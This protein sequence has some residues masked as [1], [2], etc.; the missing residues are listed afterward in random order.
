M[1]YGP[2]ATGAPAA[3]GAGAVD[4]LQAHFQ[5]AAT[6]ACLADAA[7][8]AGVMRNLAMES[9]CSQ[10]ATSDL[11]SVEESLK[12]LAFQPDFPSCSP[13]TAA[14]LQHRTAAAFF[15]CNTVSFLDGKAVSVIWLGQLQNALKL[16]HDRVV[17]ALLRLRNAADVGCSQRRFL[18]FPSA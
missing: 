16:D 10:V 1:T 17:G 9:S 6:A 4:S 13:K 18:A 5:Q 7:E 11:A 3:G 2:G 12:S 8:A 15:D 14:I